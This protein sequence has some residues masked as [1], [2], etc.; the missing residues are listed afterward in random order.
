MKFL[1][2]GFVCLTSALVIF[3]ASLN[4][5][6]Y[7]AHA[8]PTASIQNVLLD[9][10]GSLPNVKF[11]VYFTPEAVNVRHDLGFRL[12]DSAGN[13]IQNGWQWGHATQPFNFCTNGDGGSTLKWNTSYT[14][15][16]WGANSNLFTSN[17]SGPTLASYSFSTG[18][19]PATTTTT[20]TSTTTPA[21]SSTKPFTGWT[22]RIAQLSQNQ[23][24]INGCLDNTGSSTPLIVTASWTVSKD[25]VTVGS[26]SGTS[27]GLIL[28]GSSNP[29]CP[30]EFLANVSGL[31]ASTEYVVTYTGGISGNIVTG[32]RTIITSNAPATTTTTSTTTTTTTTIP[33]TT[34]TS[35]TVAPK[36]TTTVQP[37]SSTVVISGQVTTTT[38]AVVVDDGVEEGEVVADISLQKSGNS[39]MIRVASNR[40]KTQMQI[41]ARKKGAKN[42]VWTLTSDGNGAK[43]ILTS[44]NLK[45]FTLALRV[46][47]ETVD[48]AKVS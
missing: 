38:M 26:G 9:T 12:T 25:G 30:T 3:L 45:G 18:S 37:T 28:S 14:I 15:R 31:T 39:Y 42:I 22:L 16:A 1:G 36:V 6:V 32:S 34:T 4:F 23:M 24:Q 17:E 46:D 27:N 41:I 48:T 35:T 33:K 10:T 20:S 47:G 43:S 13:S 19:A 40:E 5:G 2:K 44:R 29:V 8:A 11:C 21:S 7:P